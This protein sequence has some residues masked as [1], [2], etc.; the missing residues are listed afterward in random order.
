MLNVALGDPKKL[1]K[2][3][4]NNT[5][6]IFVQIQICLFKNKNL[7]CINFDYRSEK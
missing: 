3:C 5:P 7:T 2:D 6:L 4:I 1:D